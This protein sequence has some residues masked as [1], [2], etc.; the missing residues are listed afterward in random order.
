MAIS[1]LYA[2]VA[3]DWTNTGE[4]EQISKH[5]LL[6]GARFNLNKICHGI[7]DKALYE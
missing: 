1:E 5:L 3:K 4:T 7:N 2:D 6:I